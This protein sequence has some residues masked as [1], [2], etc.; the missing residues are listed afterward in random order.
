M[1]KT[2]YQRCECCGLPF[3]AA[4]R[5]DMYS[6]TGDSSPRRPARMLCGTCRYH[7]GDAPEQQL[8][9][10]REHE[11]ELR[12]AL[13]AAAD[14]AERTQ[15]DVRVSREKVSAALDSRDRAIEKLQA[16]NDLHELRPNGACS[17]GVKSNCRTAAVLYDRWLQGMIS[18]ADARNRRD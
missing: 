11:P 3:L 13:K 10:Y 8:K 2:A 14:Y 7:Q 6:V 12:K 15:R 18:R 17:C 5:G 1:T 4:D 16:A 9:R